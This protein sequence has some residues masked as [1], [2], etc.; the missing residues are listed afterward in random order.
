MGIETGNHKHVL[1]YFRQALMVDLE[2]SR[3]N[4]AVGSSKTQSFFPKFFNSYI[5]ITGIHVASI[6]GAW[7]NVVHGFGGFKVVNSRMTFNPYIP[8]RSE[9]KKED[10]FDGVNFKLIWRGNLLNVDIQRRNATLFLQPLIEK[11]PEESISFSG[12]EYVLKPNKKLE[13][14]F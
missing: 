5:K 4:S 12:K 8:N 9:G 13:I 11:C 2:N 1:P 3:G 14:K 7:Q 10:T 6:G